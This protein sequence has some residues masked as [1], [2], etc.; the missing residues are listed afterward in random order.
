MLWPS[1][2][3]FEGLHVMDL[4]VG[5][6]KT[7]G[8]AHNVVSAVACRARVELKDLGQCRIAHNAE[9]VRV[10]ADKEVGLALL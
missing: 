5:Q 9:D 7:Q 8:C 6:G 2:L 3:K 1:R 10:A 4:A